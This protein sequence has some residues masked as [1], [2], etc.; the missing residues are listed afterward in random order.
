[1]SV[2]GAGNR[3]VRDA[4]IVIGLLAPGP[5]NAITDVPGV[6]VGHRTVWR[7][8]P[9]GTEPVARTGLTAII[10]HQGDLFRERLYAGQAVFN[11][12]GEMTSKIV[13][14]E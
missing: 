1:M 10:P 13:I 7:G 14:D 8:D 4:G 5:H 11:G 6:R 2:T 9:G 3:R 12:Y